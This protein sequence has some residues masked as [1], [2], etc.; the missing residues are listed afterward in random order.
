[1]Q[2]FGSLELI[3][4]QPAQFGKR[5][6]TAKVISISC[7]FYKLSF[8]VY[9]NID[10]SDFSIALQLHPPKTP[11]M[12]KNVFIFEVPKTQPGSENPS[13]PRTNIKSKVKNP[14]DHQTKSKTPAKFHE[15]HFV[16][17]VP[18]IWIIESRK[19]WPFCE[20]IIPHPPIGIAEFQ[21]VHGE[22]VEE[23]DDLKWK[24][25]VTEWVRIQ[26]KYLAIIYENQG[27]EKDISECAQ[28]ELAE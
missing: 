7:T 28:N 5:E 26:L 24:I 16:E 8:K 1:M 21:K 4:G 19:T 15:G 11:L 13:S 20:V 12:Q 27:Q 17:N 9:F 25:R 2:N 6:C 10:K 23:W 14:E 22:I 3:P 18:Y